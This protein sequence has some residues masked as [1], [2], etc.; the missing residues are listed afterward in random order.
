[1]HL[2]GRNSVIALLVTSLLM[3][4]MSSASLAH[5]QDAKPAEKT[6]VLRNA[7][8][9]T[10]GPKG[11]FVGSIVISDGKISEVGPD[12]KAPK[13]A[14][15]RDLKG[16]VVTPGMIESRS[17]LWLTRG[18]LGES[19]SRCEL[20]IT[21]A[22][23]PWSEDWL[24]VASQGITS[25]YVQPSSG[26]LIGGY[27]AVLRVGPYTTIDDIVIKDQVAVQAALGVQSNS[28]SQSRHTLVGQLDRL[29]SAEKTKMEKEEKDKKA[30]DEKKKTTKKDSAKPEKKDDK[31]KPEE[32]DSKDSE[33]EKEDTKKEKPKKDSKDSKEDGKDSKEDD[34][35]KSK[36]A[37]KGKDDDKDAKKE[38]TK[39]T[40]AAIALRKVLKKEIPLFVEVRHSDTLEKLLKLAKKL[41]IEIVIDGFAPTDGY[42]QK[43]ADSG[44][45]MVVGP[46]FRS[47]GSTDSQEQS[48]ALAELKDSLFSISG[49]GSSPRSS[50]M[51]RMHAA[52]AIRMGL[53]HDS[54]LAAL[55]SRPARKLGIS[56]QVGTLET[57]KV[58]DI[59]VFNGDPLDP[60]SKACLVISQGKI[61]F[62]CESNASPQSE[63]KVA[64]S[65]PDRL[66]E[67]Y[68][69]KSTRVLRKGKFVDTQFTVKSGKIFGGKTKGDIRVFDLGDTIVTPGLVIASSMLGQESAIVDASDSDTSHL[70]AVDAIDPGHSRVKPI[71]QGGFI[72]VGVSPGTSNTSPG[73]MGHIRLNAHDYVA[74][75][76][77]ASQ[78]VLSSSARQSGR[79][80]SSFNG[81]LRVIK[82]LMKGKAR[83]T[84]LYLTPIMQRLLG[85]EKVANVQAVVKGERKA[86]LD[87][88]SKLEIRSA[89]G[90]A[91]EHG[92]EAVIHSSGRVGD[93]A[94]ELA[95]NKLGLIVPTMT[96]TEYDAQ[97]DQFVMAQKAGVPIGFAGVSPEAIRFTAS[98]L[99]SRGMD[100]KAA[101][102]G[103]T[104]G[105]AGVVGMKRTGL[106]RGAWADFVIW[107]DSPLNLAAVPLNVVVDGQVV[108]RK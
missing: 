50:R 92:I 104:E 11:T 4:Q 43:L 108:T 10:M 27:G 8:I 93:F 103:L 44:M 84:S 80:P 105:G 96:G 72:H 54:V 20:N 22:I 78:F 35:D 15:V 12:V 58:A 34:K 70:R 6:M 91:R 42:A 83:D 97:L 24:E 36:D 74:S 45:P 64:K 38:K 60:C 87:A 53:D 99:V 106:T 95:E 2:A 69:V 5:G 94:S 82:N 101:L 1:M 25:V 79:Y 102:L 51:L 98:L 7:T 56:D 81:Q 18:A 23:D 86:I 16:F 62:E 39:L 40:P 37:D 41:E 59:A 47:T 76:T 21:D 67:Q 88:D 13:D 48:E 77:I 29:L 32:K 75:P 3:A 61:T 26:S 55:T 9:H 52:M 19:N 100:G 33:Q 90:L 46:L 31:K 73:V 14:V 17:K 49:F 63:A 68:I 65:L 57:G 107:S 89:I 28:T 30:A 71:L 66:P 85:Q